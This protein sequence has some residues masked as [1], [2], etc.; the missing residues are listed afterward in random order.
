ML[1]RMTLTGLLVLGSVPGSA[2]LLADGGKATIT[3]ALC[4]SPEPA[5]KTAARE[6]AA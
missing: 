4:D 6:L 5:E 3:I 1:L 2:L